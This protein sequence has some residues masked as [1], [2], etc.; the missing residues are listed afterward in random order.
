MVQMLEQELLALVAP[1]DLLVK[2]PM[3]DKQP[4]VYPHMPPPERAAFCARA[5]WWT[6]P[7]IVG[8]SGGSGATSIIRRRARMKPMMRER[9]CEHK[10][11]TQ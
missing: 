2:A 4:L 1:L 11:G 5:P 7:V 10:A 6:A 3:A 9:R 8:G